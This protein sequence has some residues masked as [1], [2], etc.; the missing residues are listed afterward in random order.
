MNAHGL[1]GEPAKELGG[2]G[3]LGP[4]LAERLAHLQRHQQRQLVA[5]IDDRLERAAQDLAALARR[6]RGPLGLRLGRRR[7]C[8]QRV[9]DL[10]VGDLHERLAGGRVLDGQRPATG[11]VAPA[12]ADVQLLGDA[13]EHGLR[14]RRR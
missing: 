5:A 14:R 10:R 4:R 1:L 13:V 2:V 12:P 11:R 8:R 3:D 7:Q 9:V 6:M